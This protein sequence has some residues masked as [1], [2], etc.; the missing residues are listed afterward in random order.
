MAPEVA[1]MRTPEPGVEG[2][3]SESDQAGI[4]RKRLAGLLFEL[5]RAIN[6]D[7]AAKVPSLL[8][9]DPRLT[10]LRT[11]LMG[12]EQALLARLAG[13]LDDPEQLAAA[14]SEVL[15]SA[16]LQAAARDERLGHVLAPTVERAA[17]SS[18]RRDPR[19]LVNILSPLMAP[20]IRRSIGEAIESMLQSLNEA[21]K[22]SFSWRGLK[23][24]LEAWRTGTPFAAV[25]LKHT[26]V[27]RVEHLFLIH[28]ESGL[29]IEHVAADPAASR[30]PQLI[31][32]MLSAIQD[33]VRDSFA[34]TAGGEVD[35]MRLGELLIWR[36]DGP[37]AFLAAVIRGKPPESLHALF[38]STLAQIHV[39]RHHALKNFDGDGAAFPG[40][41]DQLTECLLQQ[42]KPPDRRTSAILWLLLFAVLALVV[43]GA[44]AWYERHQENA[45]WA[46]YLR[47]LQAEPGIVVTGAER[48]HGKLHVTG[49]RDPLA[50]RPEA[51]L[52]GFALAPEK[53]VGS[54]S[55]Y[56]A[57]HPAFLFRRVQ[58]SLDPL[59]SVELRLEGEAVRA[60]G[61]AP[62]HWIEKARA[63]GRLLPAGALDLDL[64]GVKDVD[65]TEVERLRASIEA[66]LIRF[67]TDA[68][69]PAPGQDAI[70]DNVAAE[71]RALAELT[72]SLGLSMRATIIGHADA[73]GKDAPNLA[74]SLGRAEVV[75]SLLRTKGIDP[76]LLSVRGAG[77]LEPTQDQVAAPDPSRD[78][79]VSF[80]IRISE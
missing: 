70:V 28:K 7:F 75:R 33:F 48:R 20:A 24:R 17:E 14:V 61:S 59:Q 40:L 36:S 21:L 80:T 71:L 13:R 78:R 34:E 30:D 44:Y 50:V 60:Y 67:D 74:L 15:P 37:H 46:G 55:P 57:L 2:L 66:R 73:T 18:I 58:A 16:I 77:T 68:P 6:Q 65:M 27:Y 4:D 25:V 35:A 72:R 32:G 9:A 52:D 3:D 51:L 53:V 62:R 54:W 11:I 76:D 42:A 38:E 1:T 26:L 45:Q 31:S 12:R 49:L 56:Q 10:E 63:V 22:A 39:E 8:P 69:R 29:L 47:R 23:W 19:T 5:A 41:R 64:S 79:R 43:W